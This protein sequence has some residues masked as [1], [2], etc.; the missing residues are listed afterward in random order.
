M[1]RPPFGGSELELERIYSYRKAL[2]DLKQQGHFR[3]EKP[4][5]EEDAEPAAQDGKGGKRGGRGR[6]RNK[7]KDK[8]KD[9]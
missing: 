6:N 2:R 8:D 5:E 7:D 1:A 4:D 3:G 9:E